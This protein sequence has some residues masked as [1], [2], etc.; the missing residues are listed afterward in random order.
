MSMV[1]IVVLTMFEEDMTLGYTTL[2]G[3]YFD[4]SLA[5]GAASLATQSIS[6][7]HHGED[8]HFPEETY[9]HTVWLADDNVEVS[10]LMAPLWYVQTHGIALNWQRLRLLICTGGERTPISTVPMSP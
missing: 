10:I 4:P 3:Q 2:H 9:S 1:Y 6:I 8:G 5:T 7:H